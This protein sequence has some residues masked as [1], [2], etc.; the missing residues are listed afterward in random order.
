MEDKNKKDIPELS[1]KKN[2]LG[3]W[4]AFFINRYR[5]TYLLIII[6]FFWGI[7]QY[8]GLQREA[9]P[10]VTIPFAVVQTTYIGASPEEVESLVT[11]PIEKKLEELTDVR[12][13][14]SGSTFGQSTIFIEFDSGSDIQE[15]VRE[16]REKILDI[17]DTLPVDVE[18]PRVMDMKTGESPVLVFTL[19]GNRET[20]EIQES[21]EKIKNLIESV[22]GV[23]E[24]ALVGDIK[25]EIRVI[26]DP[27]KLSVYNISLQDI[28]NALIQSN[29]NLP[30]GDIKLNEIHYNVRTI[31]RFEKVEELGSVIIKDL[32]NGKVHLRDI[33]MI[34]DGYEDVKKFVRKPV[35]SEEEPYIENAIAISVKKKESADDII[36]KDAILKRLNEHQEGLYPSDM[37]LELVSDKAHYVASQLGSVTDNAKSGL[38]LVIVVLFLFIGFKESL[39]VAFVIPLSIFTAF[40]LM[41]VSGMTLNEIT[42][43]SLVLAVGMLVDNAIVVMEN[44]DRLRFKGLSSKLAAEV[45]TNQVAPAIMA[46]TLTT[47]AAF[48]PLS[49]TSGIMG[50][51][52]RPIPLTVIFT[53]T[54]S[55]FMAITIAPSICAGMIKTHRSHK[56]KSEGFKKQNYIKW[57]S[58]V[59]VFVLS[60]IAF[61]DWSQEGVKQYGMLS[62]T[63]AVVFGFIMFLKQF[64]FKGGHEESKV[65]SYY[66]KCLG[67]VI[68]TTKRKL[69][70]IGMIFLAFIISIGLIPLGIL[71]VEMFG[72]EDMPSF[73]VEISTPQGSNLEETLEI[74]E[75]VEK[76][77]FN[78][79]EINHFVSYVGDEGTDIWSDFTVEGPDMPNKG[80][81]IVELKEEVHRER[82]S[83]Q[84]ASEIRSHVRKIAGAEIK[85]IELEAGPPT[86]APIYLK[87]KGENLEDLENTARDFAEI[88]KSLEGARD[89]KTSIGEGMP[90]LQVRVNQAKASTLG[91]DNMSIALSIRNVIHGIKATTFRE[92]QD[93][94]D[95]IIRTSKDRLRT[96]RDIEKIFFYTPRGEAVPFSQ[97]AEIVETESIMNISHEDGKRRIAVSGEIDAERVTAVEVINKFKE[98]IKDYSMPQGVVLEFGGEMEEMGESFE[99]MMNNMILAAILVYIILAIQFNSLTQPLIILFTVP[100]ALIGVMPGLLITGN[101][102]GF[103]AFVGL[104]ALV[105]IAVNDAIVL[106]DYINYLRGTGY[107][108]REAILETGKTRFLPVLAT[109]I[110]TAGGILPITL[111]EAFFAPLGIALISGLCM[112]TLLT[113]VVVPT[114]YS[115]L[116]EHKTKRSNKK[117]K[118]LSSSC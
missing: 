11:D 102:F 74:V 81:I 22:E 114:M 42:M 78:I 88:L 67:W 50:E 80:R 5:V 33:A 68:T 56:T 108:T 38:L 16:T 23:T 91:L 101:K 47:L 59:F 99:D 21:A 65:I 41:K 46:S 1:Q 15:K 95:V 84:I 14:T 94:I 86:G 82:T 109:T 90:E 73:Y 28:K 105:G 9:Q 43:F 104:V 64:K 36:V 32:G 10:K 26:V 57:I 77:L 6:I 118:P 113:L 79:N 35:L 85:V 53:L 97:V 111:K 13:I 30:G 44:I 61:K 76:Y 20:L 54:A 89:I 40:G 34:E 45:G 63:M 87:I 27:Q 112:A 29:V 110:T 106:V 116:E 115:I 58:V 49:L 8:S 17:S 7:T 96:V 31:G 18:T 37:T 4:S 66:Q 60:L 51:F 98:E 100:M 19:R 75:E 25:R 39:I 12:R 71:K 48:F 117:T 69:L 92:N 93:E 62:I 103:V 24:V 70:F 55:F 83:V 72:E 2:F 3:R 52:I 107:D